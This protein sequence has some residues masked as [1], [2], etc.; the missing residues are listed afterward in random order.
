MD[1]AT[2]VGTIVTNNGGLLLFGK[3]GEPATGFVTVQKVAS[4]ALAGLDNP[5]ILL[6]IRTFLT[7]NLFLDD[8]V[9]VFRRGGRL[10]LTRIKLF[11][12]QEE[13]EANARFLNIAYIVNVATKATI[14]VGDFQPDVPG[15][16]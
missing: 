12:T 7:E 15:E 5:T 14:Q 6:I 3:T 4:Y 2:R 16:V 1:L 8:G 11:E 9:A 10:H 13:A